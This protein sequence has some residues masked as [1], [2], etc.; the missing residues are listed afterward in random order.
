MGRARADNPS[1][2]TS[3]IITSGRKQTSEFHDFVKVI[4]SLGESRTRI[5]T[6]PTMEQDHFDVML[7]VRTWRP[8]LFSPL[9]VLNAQFLKSNENYNNTDSEADF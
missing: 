8:L 4:T 9:E 7:M 6:I 1:R 2:S 5:Q 3:L